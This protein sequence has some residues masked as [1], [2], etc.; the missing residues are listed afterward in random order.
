MIRRQSKYHC[1]TCGKRD[2]DVRPDFN[3]REPVRVMGYR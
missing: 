2:A 1:T 3:W